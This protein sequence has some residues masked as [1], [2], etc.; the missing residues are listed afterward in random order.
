MRSVWLS[1]IRRCCSWDVCCWP[2]SGKPSR[3]SLLWSGRWADCG[4]CIILQEIE[5]PLSPSDSEDSLNRFLLYGET[6][7]LS[8]ACPS[9]VNVRALLQ[10]ATATWIP[11]W[12][13]PF[14]NGQLVTTCWPASHCLRK[15]VWRQLAHTTRQHENKLNVYF[16]QL[17]NFVT[18]DLRM[19]WEQL[20]RITWVLTPTSWQECAHFTGCCCSLGG[21]KDCSGFC[22]W[23]LMELPQEGE[24]QAFNHRYF[25]DVDVIVIVASVSFCFNKP[26]ETVG[27][28]LGAECISATESF[29]PIPVLKT[30]V[31]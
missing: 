1:E 6:R 12:W 10:R 14:W 26:S 24:L 7:L 8:T 13:R 2:I 28:S 16:F 22:C 5:P 15:K 25:W 23:I 9:A 3:R 27:L 30:T 18:E 31:C 4:E 19:R 20:L 21:N 17:Q 11:V 29:K